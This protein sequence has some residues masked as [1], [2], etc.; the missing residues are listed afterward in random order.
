MACRIVG[1]S[2]FY[3][4][5]MQTKGIVLVIHSVHVDLVYVVINTHAVDVITTNLSALF[6]GLQSSLG[7]AL[8]TSSFGEPSGDEE[9][10]RY[11][12]DEG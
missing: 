9:G 4:H 3:N 10:D 7:A 8:N 6:S 1:Q 2:E 5:C 12:E 11:D